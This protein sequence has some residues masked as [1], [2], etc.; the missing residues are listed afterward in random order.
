MYV[1]NTVYLISGLT[2]AKPKKGQQYYKAP[3]A[4][5]AHRVNLQPRDIQLVEGLEVKLIGT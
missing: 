1:L 2:R 3:S 5:Q 4:I